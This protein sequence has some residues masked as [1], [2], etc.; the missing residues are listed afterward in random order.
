MDLDHGYFLYLILAKRNLVEEEE[1][2]SSKI[3]QVVNLKGNM[4]GQKWFAL[5]IL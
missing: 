4:L 3:N 2:K 5:D 1:Q